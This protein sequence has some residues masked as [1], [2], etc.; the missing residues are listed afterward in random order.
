M[1]SVMVVCDV[2][3]LFKKG[4]SYKKEGKQLTRSSI[5]LTR[6]YVEDKNLYWDVNGLWHEVDEDAT[7]KFY[8]LREEARLA[9]INDNKVTSHVK[10]LLKDVIV[11]G[12]ETVIAEIPVKKE[13][14]NSELDLARAE[15]KV[16]YDKNP[17]HMWKLEKINEKINEKK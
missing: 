7:K 10:N 12:A 8:E 3:E 1:E 14:N 5:A 11:Q 2:Y 9:R 17:H 6:T 13:G 16:L 15:Y 4:T